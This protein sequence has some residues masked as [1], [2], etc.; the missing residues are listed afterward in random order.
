MRGLLGY[1]QNLPRQTRPLE[2]VPPWPKI[3]SEFFCSYEL[4]ELLDNFAV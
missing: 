1:A 2:I 3:F 4:V